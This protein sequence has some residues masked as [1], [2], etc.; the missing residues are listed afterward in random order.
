MIDW[1]LKTKRLVLLAGSLFV[2]LDIIMG[3]M[4]FIEIQ[5]LATLLSTPF[6]LYFLIDLVK[7][8]KEL[9]GAKEQ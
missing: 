1:N 7:K 6:I 5:P 4:A 9:K 3:Y 8:E 2:G